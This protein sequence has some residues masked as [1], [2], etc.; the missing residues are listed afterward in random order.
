MNWEYCLASFPG[1]S[2]FSNV[3]RRKR[4][5]PGKIYHVS[6]VGW[7]GLGQAARARSIVDIESGPFFFLHPAVYSLARSICL[8]KIQGYHQNSWIL[9]QSKFIVDAYERARRLA[10]SLPPYVTHVINF[11]RLPPFPACNIGK[12]RGAW[13]RG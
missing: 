12:S 5:E 11:T 3:A 2:R 6:D 10:K 13:G 8:Q 9:V 7:K 4:R 1:S